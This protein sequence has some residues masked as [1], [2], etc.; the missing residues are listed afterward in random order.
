MNHFVC[1]TS[2]FHK[3][4]DD[5]FFASPSRKSQKK[6]F[7]R[8]HSKKTNPYSTRGLDKFSALL[9]DL[10]ER[11]QK[12][13][14][15]MNPQDASVVRFVYTNSD[16]VVPVVIK[17]RKKD[18]KHK[19]EEIKDR[20]VKTYSEA[21]PM[22]KPSIDQPSA[23]VEESKQPKLD[24]EKK[25]RSS[26]NMSLW[27]TWRRPSLNLPLILIL[28]LLLLTVFGRS[29]ATLC[30]CIVWYAVP[31]LKDSSKSTRSKKKKDYARRHSEKKMVTDGLLS[32]RISNSGALKDKSPTKHG[33]Q[34]SW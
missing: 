18:E 16:E 4:E 10:D 8:S 7:Y 17:V 15:Q 21:I 14:S 24:T 3:E 25:K 20:H 11:R 5:P 22:D 34:K 28:I 6:S 33:H 32:P 31:A 13:Y 23:A 29:A 30:I 12:I 27:D 9:A 19:K 1:G 26:W 2:T